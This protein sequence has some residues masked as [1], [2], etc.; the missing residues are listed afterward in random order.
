MRFDLLEAYGLDLK[1]IEILKEKYGPELLPIQKKA[2]KDEQILN[3]GNFIIFAVTS[4]GK[5]LI[6]EILALFYG[7]KGK[8][9][10]Y[11]VPTKA[12]AEEKF[13]QFS[14]DYKQVGIN[15]VIS[16]HDRR[17]FDERIEAG[18]FHI[19][20]IVY[21][22]LQAL[23][24][25]KPSLLSEVG[26]ILIDE[27]QYITDEERG[28]AL[29]ILLTR[30]LL[31]PDPPQL[32]GLSAVLA[33]CEK[34][35]DWLKAKMLKEKKRPVELRQGIFFEGK[36]HFR[37]VNSKNEGREEWFTLKSKSEADQMVE[38]ARYLAEEKGEQTV[39]FLKDKPST[40]SI[41]RKI[42]LSVDLPPARG[43]ISELLTLEDSVSRD[44]LIGFLEKGVGIHNADLS[45]EEREIIERYARQGEIRVLCTTTTLAVGMNLPMKN[46]IIDSRRW[47]FF[48]KIR[49]LEKVRILVCDFEN[50]GGRVARFGFIKDFGRAIFVTSSYVEF[51]YL[52]EK[53][54]LGDLEELTSA[55][56]KE[57]MGKHIQN[58]IASEICH[59]SEEIKKFLK[60]TFTA[61]SIWN[62]EFSDEDYEKIIQD[63][64]ELSLKWELIQ[65]D[66]KERLYP[67]QLGKIMASRGISLESAIHFLD[68]LESA[69]PAGITE[70]ELLLLLSLSKDA[71]SSYIPMNSGEKGFRGY[72]M[73]LQREVSESMEEG[74][75]IF[76]GVLKGSPRLAYEEERAIKKA[77]MLRKWISPL[78]TKAVE[79]S[80]FVYSGVI[81]RV[82]EDFSWLAEALAALAREKGW[83]ERVVEKIEELSQR[84]IYGVTAQGL[85]LS[86]IRLRGL[87][88]TYINQLLYQGYDTPEAIAEL[89]LSELERI[90]PKRLA[91]RLHQ[92]C[93]LHYAPKPE[94]S[95]N[96][97]KIKEEKAFPSLSV[98]L[99]PTSFSLL[100][101]LAKRA[102]EVVTRDEIYSHLWPDF[103]DPDGSSNPYEHQ[104]SDHKRKIISQIKK[105]VKGKMDPT[106]EEIKGLIITKRKV[107][108]MLNLKREEV[109]VLVDD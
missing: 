83:E 40:E 48:R 97:Q 38:T 60:S 24:V 98:T 43:A 66:E 52:Y 5:T 94:K 51:K 58:L 64:I 100:T 62:K 23:L 44:M 28:P 89:P 67:T 99:P 21:E 77:L 69:D 57:E 1:V 10:F 73:E 92:Y 2:F 53:Y 36:F 17:E 90:L 47:K 3:G 80:Y 93:Q 95:N 88:R 39:I 9:V 102:G 27:L 12:L 35:A 108:Y 42:S 65:K 8:R 41:A 37:E 75:D 103:S 81:R 96:S 104:I 33:K 13:E 15:T 16:T 34:L 56:D 6:G 72:R 20:V 84:L 30:I 78:E 26:L 54:I 109:W 19:A 82:G 86:R 55:L 4:A 49:S 76:Q 25:K 45:W 101:L 61:Y 59:T 68:F 18:N 11:L 63:T 22:K 14:E 106:S 107:G 29:E 50:M 32:V 91:Q 70:L 85:P 71:Y 105:A 7:S 74:K 79:N 31:A 46:A 87:G